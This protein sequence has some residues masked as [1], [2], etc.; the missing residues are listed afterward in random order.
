MYLANKTAKSVL[1]PQAFLED[2]ISLY[3]LKGGI[4]G[5]SLAT[6]ISAVEDVPRAH[7]DEAMKDFSYRE[8]ERVP[9]HHLITQLA[10]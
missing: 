8:R 3:R 7:A 9:P 10:R 6:A 2:S 1:G 4:S 5:G